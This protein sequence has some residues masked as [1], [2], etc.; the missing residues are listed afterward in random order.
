MHTT[1]ISIL[2][3]RCL[4]AYI[5]YGSVGKTYESLRGRSFTALRSRL[6]ILHDLAPF[7]INYVV[8]AFTMPDLDAA[9]LLAAEVGAS[10]FLLLPEQPV[11][12]RG[13]IDQYTS[14]ALQRWVNNYSSKIPLLVS[15]AGAEGL[16][17]CN[18]LAG[19][20]GLRA[21]AHIDATGMLKRSSYDTDGVIIGTNSLLHTLKILQRYP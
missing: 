4:E 8:N 7:G 9:I 18:P 10:E 5:L 15:E 14:L 11:R 2:L 19:E 20:T 6:E 21:Y 17:I 13:G 3:Q 1:L 12:G 16:P